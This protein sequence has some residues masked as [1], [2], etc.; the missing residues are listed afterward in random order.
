MQNVNLKHLQLWY[1]KLA[2]AWFHSCVAQRAVESSCKMVVQVG[3]II[4][5]S[6]FVPPVVW[7][8][9]S[10]FGDHPE[11]VRPAGYCGDARF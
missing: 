5:Y 10:C 2:G 4:A 7:I 3:G 6:H 8:W 1:T 9:A 11:R